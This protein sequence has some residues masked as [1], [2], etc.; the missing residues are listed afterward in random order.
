MWYE[1]LKLFRQIHVKAAFFV[2]VILSAVLGMVSANSFRSRVSVDHSNHLTGKKAFANERR[3]YEAVSGEVTVE[4]LNEALQYIQSFSEE[5][6]ALAKGEEEYPGMIHMLENAYAASDGHFTLFEITDANDFYQ[7]I[8]DQIQLRIEDKGYQFSERDK[9]NILAWAKKIRQPYVNELAAPWS[10]F[11]T[12]FQFVLLLNFFTVIIYASNLYSN[13]K[14]QRM[15]L[16]IGT[17]EPRTIHKIVTDK[18][19]SLAFLTGGQ[20]LVSMAA[21]CAVFFGTSGPIAW[22]SQIQIW[23]FTSILPFSYQSVFFLTFFSGLFACLA[24]AYFTAALNARIEKSM[25]A[26]VTGIAVTFVPLLLRNFSMLPTGIMK[27]I[28]VLPV[29]TAMIENIITSLYLYPFPGNGMPSIYA[30]PVVSVVL[31]AVFAWCSVRMAGKY[32]CMD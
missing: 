16:I 6:S 24:A 20:Y 11:Y 9:K 17:M 19:K 31:A 5:W 1:F 12:A 32:M 15:D 8:Q 30:V 26:L 22:K 27:F 7:K 13:E 23:F 21:V 10:R 3:K 14:I 4:K 2:V 29:N 25:P 18:A 28:Q